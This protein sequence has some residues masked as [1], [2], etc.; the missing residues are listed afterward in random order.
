M[1]RFSFVALLMLAVSAF[2]ASAQYYQIANQLPQ[3][4][5]PALSGSLNYKGYVE[6][7]GI[8]GMG[9]N[10]A[11]FVGLSTTQGFRYASWFY[12]GVGAGVDM[13]IAQQPSSFTANPDY[14]YMSRPTTDKKAMIP[15]FSDF[16]FNFGPKSGVSF[17]ADIKVGAAWLI[18]SSYLRMNDA[19]MGTA[20]Q[21]YF[22]PSLGFRVPFS[23]QSKQALNAG[24][25]Y[26]LLTSNNNY[27]YDSTG[28]TLNGL[29]ISISF[30]W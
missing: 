21:F 10:R 27:Y 23:P 20:A 3:L 17:Y 28:V 6:L 25:I 19:F 1:K 5:Q 29:G 18:G 11:N 14:G 12:M 8:V 24:I 15:L 13:V 26:Q 4:I 2:S 7:A 9:H 22:R 16:R 30:E